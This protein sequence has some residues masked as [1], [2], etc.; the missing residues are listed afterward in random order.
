MH[1]QPQSL[2][3]KL[4]VTYCVELH[5]QQDL[6]LSMNPARCIIFPD[7]GAAAVAAKDVS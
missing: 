6:Y 5:L 4:Q 3:S 7:I 2:A 1:P